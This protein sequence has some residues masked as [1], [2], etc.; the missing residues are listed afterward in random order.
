[1]KEYIDRYLV[2]RLKSMNFGDN[3][4]PATWEPIELGKENASILQAMITA[5]LTSGAV[6]VDL[7]EFGQA[8]GLTLHEVKQIV[9]PTTS[10]GPGTG[11]SGIGAVP[12]QPPPPPPVVAPGG[13]RSP[14][15]GQQ[16]GSGKPRGV[17][18]ARAT[19][20]Q[21]SHRVKSQ[22]ERAWRENRFGA[23]LQLS[24]GYHR[25]MTESFRAEGWTHDE[26]TTVTDE[27]YSSLD[28]WSKE[29]LALGME[30]FDSP[31]DFMAL[32]NRHLENTLSDV[33]E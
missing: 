29:V 31:N 30:S 18:E 26:A 32:F 15:H 14:R 3:A 2:D 4:P 9:N 22:I 1:M 11:E 17:G 7:E 27:F 21:I 19:G 16:T 33:V 28:T 8:L 25:R 23:D 5:L 6:G 13:P 10:G 20:R 24:P 12:Q